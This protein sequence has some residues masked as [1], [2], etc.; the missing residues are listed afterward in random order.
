MLKIGLT[1]GIAAGKSIV[2]GRLRELGAVLID[3]DVL[4]REVVE[5]GTEGLRLIVETFGSSVLTSEGTLNRPALG[6]I[7]FG[8]ETK[9]AQLNSIVHP[10]VRERAAGMLAAAAADAVVVQD[11]PLL[12]ET[13]QAP[14]FHLVVVVHAPQEVRIRRMITDRGMSLQE[15]EDRIASQASDGER[16]AAADVLLDNSGSREA[17]LAAVDELW[18]TRLVPFAHNLQAGRTSRLARPVISDYNPKWPAAAA[19]LC[20]RIRAAVP[21][22]ILAVDHIGSTA[23]PGLA[24]KDIIDLQV[25]VRSLADADGFAGA[26]AAAGFPAYPGKWFDNPKPGHPDPGHWAKRFHGSADPGRVVHLHIRQA[27][28]PGWRYALAFRDWLREDHHSVEEYLALKR[29][30][31]QAHADD[32]GTAGYAQAKEPWLTEIGTPRLEAWIRSSG[33]RPPSYPGGAED[34]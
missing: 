1:G 15:A 20:A 30:L 27:G 24:A 34:S 17:T 10:L 28:S 18:H 14:G 2:A 19:R 3:A 22:G 16:R 13:G 8:D 6:S 25:A 29:R 21:E 31:A 26:L 23:V 4:A 12:V 5:P 32:A 9:R 33:W 11:I 7:V